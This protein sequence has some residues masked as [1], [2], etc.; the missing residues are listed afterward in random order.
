MI[1]I[2]PMVR[3]DLALGM[4]L[5]QQAG[6]NQ[7]EADWL[8]QL[9]LEPQ[10]CFVAEV[11]GAP[12]GTTCTCQFG[13][14]AWVA[15]VLVD[16]AVR[17]RGI[18]QALVEHALAH[19]D[20]R[21]MSSIR[22]DATAL[23]RP[24]YE[25]LGFAPQ[26]ELARWEGVLPPSPAVAGVTPLASEELPQLLDLDRGAV[27]TDRGKLLARLYREQPESL[28]AV[29]ERDRVVGFAASRA[30]AN[31]TQ[32][33]PCIADAQA[34]PLLLAD[35]FHRHAGQRVYLDVPLANAAAMEAARAQGLTVQ[36][37]FLRMCR[38]RVVEENPAS[39]WASFGP[40]KG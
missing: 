35:A 33:G 30:G 2:R 22:L 32:L 25:K 17:R 23:G 11:D 27:A 8:R 9:E 6:W 38:G 34:G 26:F 3:E 40:E 15:I 28:R 18:G 20:E 31:A 10:G 37:N 39:F 19:L 14:V 12:R 5:K 1:H 24:L 21:G 29:R 13:P 36:R 7:T 4:R 16:V